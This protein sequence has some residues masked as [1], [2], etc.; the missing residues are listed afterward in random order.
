MPRGNFVGTAFLIGMVLLG[1]GAMFLIVW[2]APPQHPL[3]LSGGRSFPSFTDAGERV[4]IRS[5]NGGELYWSAMPDGPLR[6]AGTDAVDVPWRPD[7]HRTERMMAIPTSMFWQRPLPR[8]PSAAILRAAEVDAYGRLGPVRLHARPMVEHGALSLLFLCLPESALFDADTGIYVVGNAMLNGVHPKD[9]K[10]ERAPNKFRYPGNFHGRGQ[11][12][13]RR[14]LARFVDPDGAERFQGE[15]GVRIHGQMTRAF[16]QHALRLI[17]DPPSPVPLY[18]PGEG[19][20]TKVA[21]ARAA[22][23]DQVKAFMR[24]ALLQRLCAESMS[25][26]SASSSHVLYI[27]GAYWGIHHLRQRVDEHELAR[28]HGVLPKEVALV[29]EL[30]GSMV[31]N[32]PDVEDFERLRL[33]AEKWDGIRQGSIDRLEAMLNVDAFLEYMAIMLFVD[34]SDWP[35]DNIRFWRRTGKAAEQDPRWHPI[36]QDLDLAFGHM[37][38]SS[39]DPLPH[40][41]GTNS[42]TAGLFRALMKSRTMR[43]RFNVHMERVAG[44]LLSTERV[45]QHIDSM[46]ALLLPEMERHVARWRR[47]ATLEAWQAEVEALRTFARERPA[48]MRSRSLQAPF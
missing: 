8:Q 40:L 6:A 35:G 44:E 28:R 5:S 3:P 16:P 7:A 47:P 33:R 12:W 4:H 34:N 41:A 2:V 20:G 19:M 15:V 25:E 38:P 9:F 32:T 29:E 22:G 21:I 24:D 42:P 37:R 14:A 45:I 31:G 17:F 26:T 27:N 18:V 10:Y 46:E 11:T 23:N 13:E 48:Y 36:I 39:F 30:M 43:E 1:M